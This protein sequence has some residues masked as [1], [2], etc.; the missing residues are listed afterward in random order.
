LPVRGQLF[1]AVGTHGR[2]ERRPPGPVRKRWRPRHRH[3][4][5]S[6]TGLV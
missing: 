6:Q 3:R 1:I 5:R 2:L 4:G